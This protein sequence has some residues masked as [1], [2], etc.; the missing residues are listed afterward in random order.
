MKHLGCFDADTD[1]GRS[2]FSPGKKSVRELG[3]TTNYPI[4]VMSAIV[5]I[6]LSPPRMDL[7][8]DRELICRDILTGWD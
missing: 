1:T 3:P 8:R 2:C 7:G 4:I 6:V 5:K